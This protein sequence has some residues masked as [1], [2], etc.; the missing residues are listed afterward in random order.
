MGE[1]GEKDEEGGERMREDEG[2]EEGVRG[3]GRR[4]GREEEEEE[5]GREKH[6]KPEDL[7]KCVEGDDSDALITAVPRLLNMLNRE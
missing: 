3:R 7:M 1:G 2:R 4:G 5:E 6:K